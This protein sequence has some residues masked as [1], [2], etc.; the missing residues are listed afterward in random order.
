MILDIDLNFIDFFYKAFFRLIEL[1][2]AI[3]GF[4]N[5]DTALLM[6]YTEEFKLTFFTGTIFEIDIFGPFRWLIKMILDMIIGSTLYSPTILEL[7]L[8]SAVIVLIIWA[9]I[10]KVVY[11]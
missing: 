10:K 7:S 11:L 8:S 5:S 1:A 3:W 2:K 4:L 6:E 9:L